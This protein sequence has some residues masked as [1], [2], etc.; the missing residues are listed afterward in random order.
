MP[1]VGEPSGDGIVDVPIPLP[2][3]P[4][5]GRAPSV[6][7]L[8]VAELEADEGVVGR[9]E[10]AC[11]VMAVVGTALVGMPLEKRD[12]L[13]PRDARDVE[14]RG[15]GW[16]GRWLFAGCGPAPG[17]VG[18]LLGRVGEEGGTGDCGGG[19]G[20]GTIAGGGETGTLGDTL[21]DASKLWSSWSGGE[22]AI[23]GEATRGWG[24]G[25]ASSELVFSSADASPKPREDDVG[26]SE[27]PACARR[28]ESEE[29]PAVGDDAERFL[30]NRR[31]VGG[32]VALKDS[33]TSGSGGPAGIG[34]ASVAGT[35]WIT[36]SK[37]GSMGGSFLDDSL[38]LEG[39]DGCVQ[40]S[41]SS[42]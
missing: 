22:A 37:G 34:I 14:R 8:T 29:G 27:G 15:E 12:E 32:R 30:G 26:G 33:S 5:I 21:R 7:S 16:L 23:V 20:D 17:E 10:T 24:R 3:A 9:V 4:G 35:G 31:E 19:G 36:G 2:S 42:I 41:T 40:S 6:W 18:L 39:Y 25:S 28:R 13:D 11:S 1:S 38:R